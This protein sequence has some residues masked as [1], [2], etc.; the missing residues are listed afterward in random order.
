M[1]RPPTFRNSSFVSHWPEAYTNHFF[2]TDPA[3]NHVMVL[4]AASETKMA[5]ISVPGAFSIDGT[6]DHSTLYVGTLIGDLYS[7][8]PVAMVV[9]KRYIGSQ[10]GPSGFFA[11]SA[12]V[13]ADGRLALLGEPRGIPSVEL[14]ELASTLPTCPA[15]IDSTTA[16]GYPFCSHQ[17]RPPPERSAVRF[18]C[19]R[20]LQP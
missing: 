10:I 11:F 15:P 2:V 17:S 12:V 4:D 13:L 8:D 14:P 18:S 9:K 3:S 20:P 6:P 1:T 7:I 5:K 19:A 16:H